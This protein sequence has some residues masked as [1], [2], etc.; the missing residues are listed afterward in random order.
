[1]KMELIGVSAFHHVARAKDTLAYLSKVSIAT[2]S[3]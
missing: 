3:G 2:Q 1:M